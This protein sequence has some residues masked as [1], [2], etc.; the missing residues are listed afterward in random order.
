MPTAEEIMARMRGT[1]ERETPEPK[2]DATTLALLSQVRGNTDYS[3]VHETN[4]QGEKEYRAALQKRVRELRARDVPYAEATARAQ[5]QREAQTRSEEEQRR[6]L[7]Q[8]MIDDGRTERERKL[9]EAKEAASR[10]AR[11]RFLPNGRPAPGTTVN[12]LIQDGSRNSMA[13]KL[14]VAYYGSWDDLAE[15]GLV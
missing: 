3:H 12:D 9:K 8:Q 15:I 13:E 11:A 2:A 10:P 6:A 7:Y 4:A 5:L 1:A 14:R